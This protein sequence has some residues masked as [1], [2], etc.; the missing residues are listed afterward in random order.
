MRV[1]L[2]HGDD[3]DEEPLALR[4]DAT[5]EDVAD[6]IHHELAETFTAARIWGPSA[7]F[8][9]QRVGRSHRVLDGDV[10]E[11]LR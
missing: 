10:V 11:I 9:G 5:V 2:R 8:G 7:R 6:G 4:P 1:F 3:V